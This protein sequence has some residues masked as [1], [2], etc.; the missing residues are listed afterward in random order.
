M[1]TY[2]TRRRARRGCVRGARAGSVQAGEIKGAD[3]VAEEG[4]EADGAH[5]DLVDQ[6]HVARSELVEVVWRLTTDT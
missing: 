6:Q 1:T 5:A 4:V 2:L 3:V